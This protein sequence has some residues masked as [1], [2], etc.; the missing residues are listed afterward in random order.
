MEIVK[1]GNE[2][3]AKKEVLVDEKEL[4]LMNARLAAAEAFKAAFEEP[5]EKPARK[6]RAKKFVP[7]GYTIAPN[8]DFPK[9]VTLELP[10]LREWTPTT[11]AK[12]GKA[13]KCVDFQTEDGKIVSVGIEG[14]KRWK[15]IFEDDACVAGMNQIFSDVEAELI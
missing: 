10:Q 8:G 1:L 3:M 7:K 4:R 13:Q 12:K 11:G 5:A 15:E 9:G 14:L 2:K 6:A